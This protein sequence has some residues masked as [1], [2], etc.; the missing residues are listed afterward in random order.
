[1]SSP[2]R[3]HLARR[4]RRQVGFGPV[5]LNLVPLVDVLTSIVFFGLLTY[6]AG[7]ALSTV[8]ALDLLS[9]P[10]IDSD[11]GTRGLRTTAPSLTLR[12]DRAGVSIA[13][14]GE[15]VERRFEGFSDE[16]L[17]LINRAIVEYGR[18][19]A[20]DASVSVIPADDL[21]Y[22]DLIRVLDEVRSAGQSRIALGTRP[23][24]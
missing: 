15:S 7:R 20:P 24:A 4:T 11:A 13:R 18:E 2:I 17:R 9:P 22:S 12:V 5:S 8:T 6:T 1:M 10:V 16:T 14:A 21:I 3:R 23:R 19:L